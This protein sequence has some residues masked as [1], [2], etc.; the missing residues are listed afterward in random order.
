LILS[1]KRQKVHFFEQKS[2]KIAQK[3][4]TSILV[5]NFTTLQL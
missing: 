3:L 1:K 4:K 2:L 5:S